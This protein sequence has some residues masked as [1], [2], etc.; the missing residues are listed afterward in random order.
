MNPRLR[1]VDDHLKHIHVLIQ[2]TSCIT[3]QRTE[4]ESWHFKMIDKKRLK[5]IFGP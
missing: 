3:I 1:Q 5:Y 2:Y 4:P